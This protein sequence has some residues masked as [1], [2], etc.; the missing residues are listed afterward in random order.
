MLQKDASDA[1]SLVAVV[2]F[3]DS[4][5]PALLVYSDLFMMSVSGLKWKCSRR[6]ERR[7]VLSG[8]FWVV[9]RVSVSS[10]TLSLNR[11]LA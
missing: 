1:T 3:F 5:I 11:V 10:S 8:Q 4:W 6:L 2:F 9:V 7:S